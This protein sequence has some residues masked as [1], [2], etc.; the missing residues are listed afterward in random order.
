MAAIH[1]GHPVPMG[2]NTPSATWASVLRGQQ[3]VMLGSALYKK[4]R[5]PIFD[6]ATQPP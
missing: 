1:D 2:Y 4:L 3:R 5:I 6:E